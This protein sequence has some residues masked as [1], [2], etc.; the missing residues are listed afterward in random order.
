[1]SVDVETPSCRS[2]QEHSVPIER[3]VSQLEDRLREQAQLIAL[4][5]GK[6]LDL[7]SS[8]KSH[9][10]T[11]IVKMNH[12]G[13]DEGTTSFK[14]SEMN[15]KPNKDERFLIIGSKK[16]DISSVPFV[17]YLQLFVTRID[18]STSCRKLAEN[19]MSDVPDL[20]SVICS[21]LK[22]KHASY[23]SFHVVVPEHQKPLVCGNQV[24]PEGA[25]IKQFSGKLLKSYVTEEFNSADPDKE[26]SQKAG[27]SAA[28]ASSSK[29]K[30]DATL[31]S[32]GNQ[33]KSSRSD[34]PS[35]SG[36]SSKRTGAAPP[37]DH[38]N[39][40][41]SPVTTLPKPSPKNTRLR[42]GSK[43]P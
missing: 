35:L 28:A 36:V 12:G 41:K 8:I 34:R 32:S 7:E 4:L 15:S 19:L 24:W 25:L 31:S 3:Y 17:R 16:S 27:S 6:I 29:K 30:S 20:C 11:D 21:K 33:P 9:S 22:T 38:L 26:A 23:A 37:L 1:M 42:A 13:G 10:F 14:R 2:V 43:N 18:P 5:N 40:K 39:N